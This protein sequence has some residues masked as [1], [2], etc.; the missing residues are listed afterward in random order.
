MNHSGAMGRL[1]GFGQLMDDAGSIQEAWVQASIH[2]TTDGQK[3]KLNEARDFL[4]WSIG[5]SEHVKAVL[6][7]KRQKSDRDRET[8]READLLAAEEQKREHNR[9]EFEKSV[10]DNFR[11]MDA[12]SF[13]CVGPMSYSQ[14]KELLQSRAFPVEVDV[15]KAWEHQTNY[16]FP[17]MRNSDP[18]IANRSL[19][20]ARH[21]LIGDLK[22]EGVK[23]NELKTD[24]EP[25]AKK[26]K[27]EK[28]HAKEDD[29]FARLSAKEADLFARLNAKEEEM[30]ARL[31]AKE[32]AKEDEML[33]R[34]SAKEDEMFARLNARLDEMSNDDKPSA[35]ID[36]SLIKDFFASHFEE[37]K[38]SHVLCS[39]LYDM[40]LKSTDQVI[41]E[42]LFKYHCKRLFLAQWTS[43]KCAHIKNKRCYLD[44]SVIE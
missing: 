4:L 42:K 12:L 38:G 9:I 20:K 15:Q 8:Q 43:S 21:V 29:V 10:A 14:A 6:E 17:D 5:S 34:L 1:G 35:K 27:V 24:V 32:A 13:D 28:S 25:P 22:A 23:T 30:L 41:D 33:A 3:S 37:K 26:Q 19:N 18:Y 7:L 36:T 11:A 44:V 16:T 2:A 40:F 31:S 39:D